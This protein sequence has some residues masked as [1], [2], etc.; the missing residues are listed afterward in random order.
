MVQPPLTLRETCSWSVV[1]RR[2]LENCFLPRAVRLAGG[3]PRTIEALSNFPKLPYATLWEAI[4]RCVHILEK[5]NLL[6]SGAQWKNLIPAFLGSQIIL[7]DINGKLVRNRIFFKYVDPLGTTGQLESFIPQ[8]PFLS[9]VAWMLTQ[10]RKDSYFSKDVQYL[11]LMIEES[12]KNQFRERDSKGEQVTTK[13][14]GEHFEKFHA[15]WEIFARQ[16]YRQLARDV[17]LS[18]FYGVQMERSVPFLFGS[19][20][21][22]FLLFTPSTLQIRSIKDLDK[23]ASQKHF[24]NSNDHV[25][26]ETTSR[27]TQICH[28]SRGWSISWI[29]FDKL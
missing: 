13:L 22:P 11:K 6:F 7:D 3:H 28:T 9:F 23:Y 10:E 17:T 14:E 4:L 26:S 25:H 12:Q 2:P 1:D 16:L 18:D 20:K 19:G 8:I 5:Y 21:S 27:R 24:V 15:Y 29:R